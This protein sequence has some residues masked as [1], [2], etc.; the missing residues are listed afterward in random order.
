MSHTMNTLT[1]TELSRD[2]MAAVED[3]LKKGPVH[4]IQH[5]RSQA[6]ILSEAEYQRLTR[7]EEQI[8]NATAEPSAWEFLLK[9]PGGCASP[10]EI[11]AHI[12]EERNAWES[13]G[14]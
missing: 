4:I 10:E 14:R 1:A 2:G 5:N 13:S 7:I 6:V 3:A 9:H 11:R 12:E 8:K